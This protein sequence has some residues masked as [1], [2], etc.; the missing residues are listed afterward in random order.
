MSWL[1]RSSCSMVTFKVHPEPQE[2]T[3]PGTFSP[4]S[5][6]SM[7]HHAC[8]ISL[9]HDSS[10][11]GGSTASRLTSMLWI[12]D[13]LPHVP[14]KLDCSSVPLTSMWSWTPSR[15]VLQKTLSF[16]TFL[17]S[18]RMLV[19]TWFTSLAGVSQDGLLHLTSCTVLWMRFRSSH[20][21]MESDTRMA[22]TWRILFGHELLDKL[23][24]TIRANPVAGDLLKLSPFTWISTAMCCC[25]LAL[26]VGL[27]SLAL[28][29]SI[30]VWIIVFVDLR[31]LLVW[32]VAGF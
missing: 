7:D 28:R 3:V 29:W 30:V 20:V 18:T 23:G 22:Y 14:G 10:P 19:G 9:T 21:A 32:G 1:P 12:L 8:A 31:E 4:G 6:T 2:S 11:T 24:G 26:R 25:T 15:F 16:G 13:T 17:L 27:W 5:L